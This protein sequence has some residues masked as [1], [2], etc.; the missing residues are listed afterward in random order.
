MII[1]FSAFVYLA[2]ASPP[3]PTPVPN[4]FNSVKKKKK[5]KKKIK[6]KNKIKPPQKK[7]KKGYFNL[8]PSSQWIPQYFLQQIYRGW[9]QLL[10]YVGH[11][12]RVERLVVRWGWGSNCVLVVGYA[13]G[14]F[15]LVGVCIWSWDLS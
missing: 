12:I 3:M 6:K 5:K 8:K 13:W 9:C 14:L 15:V 11:R 2:T 1:T 4:S 7:K 10:K